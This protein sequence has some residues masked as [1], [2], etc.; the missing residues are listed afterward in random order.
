MNLPLADR[1]AIRS[2]TDHDGERIRALVFS[3]LAEVGF[4]P[5]RV[6]KD[7]DLFDVEE[8]YLVPGRMFEVAAAGTVGFVRLD[9]R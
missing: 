9:D 8:L 1:F 2:A 3:V 6:G 4:T 7:A 5:D